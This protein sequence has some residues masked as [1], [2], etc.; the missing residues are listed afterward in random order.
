MTVRVRA[1][2]TCHRRKK[3]KKAFYVI[4]FFF[5]LSIKVTTDPIRVVSEV[6]NILKYEYKI[7]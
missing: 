6:P 7:M 3:K 4:F 2:F 1:G 5:S